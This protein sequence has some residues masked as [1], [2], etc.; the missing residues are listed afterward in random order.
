MARTS[1]KALAASIGLVM[2][3]LAVNAGLAYRNTR[4]L[5]QDAG[6]VAHTH[7]VLDLT[8]E[9]LR[10][11]TDAET[12]QRGYLVTGKVD[13]LDSYHEAVARLDQRVSNL[14]DKTADN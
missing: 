8:A 10:T 5:L 12:A 2:V 3:L 6:W 9:M 14:K 7:A 11:L 1:D 13:Y 4:Q